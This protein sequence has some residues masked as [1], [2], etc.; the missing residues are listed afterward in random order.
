[1]DVG[2]IPGETGPEARA[3]HALELWGNT[4]IVYGGE[5]SGG[6]TEN[7]AVELLGDMWA[8]NLPRALEKD[9]D[10]EVLSIEMV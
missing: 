1:M 2:A 9:Y 4:V 8:L 5:G 10:D 6:N 7:D 3:R